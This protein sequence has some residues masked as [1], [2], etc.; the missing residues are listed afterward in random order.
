MSHKLLLISMSSTLNY[1]A[2]KEDYLVWISQMVSLNGISTC[3][4]REFIN[5]FAY[6]I[7]AFMTKHGYKMKG[8]MEKELAMWMYRIHIQEVC[9]KKHG[10]MVSLPD[11]DHRDT[12]DDY[13]HYHMII[14]EDAITQFIEM[15]S[16]TEDLLAD[17]HVGNSIRYGIHAFLYRVIDI[18]SSK[19]GRFIASLW[20]SSGST[21]DSEGHEVVKSKKDDYL[22]DAKK[23]FHGGR[24]AK[25]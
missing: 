17:T 22:E 10:T 21:S 2:S 23:G 19:Q 20:D 3:S 14:G 11:I 7:R 12:Q 9:R 5:E 25:V 16:D 8:R 13:D 1:R 24:G 4:R 18:E 6:S 15:W